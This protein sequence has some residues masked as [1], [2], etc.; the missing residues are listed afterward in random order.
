MIDHGL[1]WPHDFDDLMGSPRLRFV[2]TGNTYPH[3]ETL[4]S[5]AWHW[6]AGKKAWINENEV[7]ADNP[8]IA[9]IADI[10]DI[11]VTCEGKAEAA[12]EREG[13]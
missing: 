2:A 1:G 5:W 4:A 13:E 9:A 6:N 8:C 11:T 12:R 3:R 10:P 7:S